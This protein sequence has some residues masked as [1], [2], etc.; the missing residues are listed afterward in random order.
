ML[1]R[2]M[3]IKIDTR[4]LNIISFEEPG[5]ADCR[6]SNCTHGDWFDITGK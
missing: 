6:E 5:W 3:N 1:H 2:I 4:R